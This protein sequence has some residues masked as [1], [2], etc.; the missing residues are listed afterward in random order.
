MTP[1]HFACGDAV[2]ITREWTFISPESTIYEVVARLPSEGSSPRYS[3]KTD[4]E[5]FSRVAL[6][7]TMSAVQSPE[8]NRAVVDV[9]EAF[10]MFAAA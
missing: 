2:F 6:E 10:R 3:V 8:P 5:T 7:H 4:A 9:P 1:H